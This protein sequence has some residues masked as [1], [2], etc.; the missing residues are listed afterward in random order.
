MEPQALF[1]TLVILKC[2]GGKIYIRQ[3]LGE[4]ASYEASSIYIHQGPILGL[5]LAQSI[6]LIQWSS[7]IIKAQWF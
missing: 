4:T 7:S 1:T 6:T 2:H 3:S 5:H